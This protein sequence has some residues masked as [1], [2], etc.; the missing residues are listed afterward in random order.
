MG[1]LRGWAGGGLSGLYPEHP[2][3]VSDRVIMIRA[4]CLYF[5]MAAVALCWLWRRPS[6]YQRAGVLLAFAWNLNTV[7][8]VNVLALRSGWWHFHAV[9]ALFYGMPIDLYFGWALLWGMLAPL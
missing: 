9:G 4:A 7:L 3:I 8:A 6:G 1:A 5:P 2:P